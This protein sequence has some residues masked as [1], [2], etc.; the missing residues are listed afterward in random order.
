MPLVSI[1]VP[2]FNQWHLLDSLWEALRQQL[3][4]NFEVLVV[5]NDASPAAE[6]AGLP[7]NARVLRCATPG[8]YAARNV[9]IDAAKGTWL[10][11]TDADCVPSRE[12][13]SELMSAAAKP[14]GPAI[15][16]GPVQMCAASSD[17]NPYELY[18]LFRG[19]PQERY[20]AEGYAATANLAVHRS[21]MT[22]VGLFDPERLSGGDAEFCR[23]AR[24][25]GFDIAFVAGAVVRHPCRRSWDEIRIKV[26]RIRGGQLQAGSPYR[27]RSAIV[28]PLARLLVGLGRFLTRG[29]Y[30]LRQRVAA[31]GVLLRVAL[32]ELVETARLRRGAPPERR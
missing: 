29:G 19:I 5:D 30:S 32:A 23:R 16:A 13:L 22:Q 18:D 8:S 28:F 15:L 25:A 4:R 1:V 9:G 31:S 26:R 20:V 21:V 11:F 7:E 6:P 2:V 24:A 10:V 3:F 14:S 17:P 27:Y 12:W